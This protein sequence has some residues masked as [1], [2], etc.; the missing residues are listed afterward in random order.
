M[1]SLDVCMNGRFLSSSRFYCY[2]R[3]WR[4]AW[5]MLSIQPWFSFESSCLDFC[6][7]CSITVPCRFSI[8]VVFAYVVFRHNF[9][10]RLF[11]F[12]PWFLLS[13]AVFSSNCCSSCLHIFVFAHMSSVKRQWLRYL[14][15]SFWFLRSAW[16]IQCLPVVLLPWCW[17]CCFLCVGGSSSRK[18]MEM[19][20]LV[21]YCAFI[22]AQ[23][24]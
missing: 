13:S 21:R 12:K 18:S 5:W 22:Q 1:S 17:S 20:W 14:S 11:I 8:W 7:W 15:S 6:L 10:L 9:C 16:A 4:S 3:R 19:V 2:P 23:R 24:T